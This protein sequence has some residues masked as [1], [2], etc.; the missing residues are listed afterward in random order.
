MTKVIKFYFIIFFSSLLFIFAWIGSYIGEM[1][2]LCIIIF[3]KTVKGIL[4]L[5]Q[6]QLTLVLILF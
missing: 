5:L 3:A 2:F 6:Y 1:K 4:N